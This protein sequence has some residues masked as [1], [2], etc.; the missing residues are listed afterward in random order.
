MDWFI[1]LGAVALTALGVYR[2]KQYQ[3][4]RDF[5]KELE[6]IEKELNE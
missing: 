2:W 3:E 5:R 4:V 1:F 6:Q